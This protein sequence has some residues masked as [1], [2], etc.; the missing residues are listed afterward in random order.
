MRTRRIEGPRPWQ[1]TPGEDRETGSRILQ[2]LGPD[3]HEGIPNE[4]IIA[5]NIC[6]CNPV[7]QS[8]RALTADQFLDAPRPTTPA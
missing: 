5:P 4:V 7:T 8:G 1:W 6:V 2:M 3:S